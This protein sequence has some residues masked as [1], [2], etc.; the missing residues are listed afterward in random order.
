SAGHPQVHP[1]RT[2]RAAAPRREIGTSPVDSYETTLRKLAVPDDE[3]VES[4]LGPRPEDARARSPGRPRHRPGAIRVV[5][6]DDRGGTR[7]GRDPPRDRGDA[8]GG[9]AGDRDGA[10]GGCGAE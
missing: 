8:R 2:M 4:A 7:G 9:D 1:H 5:P 3:F 6:L 10:G